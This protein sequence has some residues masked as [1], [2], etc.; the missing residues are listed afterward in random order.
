MKNEFPFSTYSIPQNY[1]PIAT[2]LGL[3][4]LAERRRVTGIKHHIEGLQIGLPFFL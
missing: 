4:S 3:P 1:T 2:H